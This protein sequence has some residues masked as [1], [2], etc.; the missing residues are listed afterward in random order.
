MLPIN[1]V[2]DRYGFLVVLSIIRR[3]RSKPV[4]LCVCSCGKKCSV[5]TYNLRNGHTISCGCARSGNGHGLSRSPEYS[6]WKHIHQ[7]CSNPHDGEYS[8]YGGRGIEVCKR[9]SSFE[10]FYEDMG[11]RPPGTTL[12]R[13]DNDGGYS[14]ENCRWVPT[15][16]QNNNQRRNVQVTFRGRTQTAS[17][18]ARE[19][20]LAP[21]VV[22]NRLRAGWGTKKALTTPL[23]KTWRCK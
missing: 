15:S 8:N 12:D 17:E 18:W 4:A 21:G 20:G 5:L 19:F 1:I 16:V 14:K 13:K 3:K 2:G 22:L 11:P 10:L 7:R 6:I 23:L 9:W